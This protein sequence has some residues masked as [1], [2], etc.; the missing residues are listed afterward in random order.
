[1]GGIIDLKIKMLTAP[2]LHLVLDW[3]K[4]DKTVLEKKVFFYFVA[5]LFFQVLYRKNR[6]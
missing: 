1:L 5:F 4:K 2:M 6:K 3:Q